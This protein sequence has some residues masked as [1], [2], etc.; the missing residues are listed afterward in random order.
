[1][2]AIHWKLAA[3][4]LGAIDRIAPVKQPLD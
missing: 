2:S 3:D 4:E 1:V